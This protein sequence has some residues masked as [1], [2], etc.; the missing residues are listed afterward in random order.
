MTEAAEARDFEA[1][2]P[3]PAVPGL[4]FRHFGGPSDYAGMNDA[5]NESRQADDDHFITPLEGFANFYEHLVNCDRERDLLIV[6]VDGAI[7]GYARTEWRDEA[8]GARIHQVICFLRPEWRQR[9]IGRA[10]LATIERRAAEVAGHQPAEQRFF[11]TDSDDRDKDALALFRDFG[12]EPVRH[13][14]SMVRPNLDPEPDA[15]L[16]A[17][18]EIREVRPEHLRAIFDA[19]DEAF[20]DHWGYRPATDVDFDLFLTDPFNAD[21]S[22]WRIAWEGDQVAGQVRGYINADENERFGHRRGW[23][24]NISV[25]RP[26]RKR[27]LARA[28]INETFAALR[29]RGM[30]EGAL[31]VD[32]ENPTGALRLYESVGFRPVSRSIVFRKPIPAGSVPQ[33]TEA[34]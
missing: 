33:P 18:L 30:T 27:G 17:G 34:R 16:P 8:D 32:A 12:Y 13:A 24:E 1:A 2:M 3:L 14:F 25:R 19:E 31:G 10:M 22:I 21:T 4:R 7:V 28:L 23:V 29:E 9:G 15:A 11:Q 20:R 5:A 26:W 6:E